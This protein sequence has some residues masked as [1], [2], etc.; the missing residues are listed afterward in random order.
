MAA[1]HHGPAAGLTVS[2]DGLIRY[3]SF[4]YPG[5]AIWVLLMGFG[6]HSDTHSYCFLV[7]QFTAFIVLLEEP[8]QRSSS[9]TL[10]RLAFLRIEQNLIGMAVFTAAELAV[11]PKRATHALHKLEGANFRHAAAEV[12]AVWAAMLRRP[13]AAAAAAGGSAAASGGGGGRPGMLLGPAAGVLLEGGIARQ[14]VLAAEAASEPHWCALFN[15][16]TQSS[17]ARSLARFLSHFTHGAL[18]K[19]HTSPLSDVSSL[20]ETDAYLLSPQQPPFLCLR[21]FHSRR[22][23]GGA[24]PAALHTALADHLDTV[25]VQLS[26]MQSAVSATEAMLSACTKAEAVAREDVVAPLRGPLSAVQIRTQALLLAIADAVDDPRRRRSRSG[27]AGGGVGGGG[28]GGSSGAGTATV[29]ARKR[30][31]GGVDDVATAAASTTGAAAAAAEEATAGGVGPRQRSARPTS[32]PAPPQQTRTPS[33]TAPSGAYWDADDEERLESAVSAAESAMAD[34]DVAYGGVIAVLRVLHRRATVAQPPHGRPLVPSG[35]IVPL[36]AML[37]ATRGALHA[38]SAAA[39]V[40][41][42]LA[43]LGDAGA[44][45]EDLPP[46]PLR[47]G[48]SAS[49]SSSAAAAGGGAR[50]KVR[51]RTASS[52]CQQQRWWNCQRCANVRLQAA[53]PTGAEHSCTNGSPIVPILKF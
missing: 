7:A 20:L 12:G 19:S 22:L 50:S 44:R 15:S 48:F 34:F 5:L 10:Q 31:E 52:S 47:R 35:A 9:A 29:E 6:R 13:A 38:A 4:V 51:A 25:S 26:L 24:F 21:R 41:R 32:V 42:D 28:A 43:L 45:R 11:F 1:G 2:A 37:H 49:G 40:V 8:P 30:D 53:V 39:A 27:G 16:L 33:R 3:V 14:R 46:P 17:P 23:L 18:K 36:H